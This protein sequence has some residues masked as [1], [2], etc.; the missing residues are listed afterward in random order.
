MSNGMFIV[1]ENMPEE[2]SAIAQAVKNAFGI[3]ST[4]E[5][6]DLEGVFTPI[7]EF[8]GY[9]NSST[10]LA[11]AI[12]KFK[13]DTGK[14]MEKAVFVLTPRDLY[15]GEVSKEDDWIFGYNI[16]E[17]SVASG[18]R[19]KREDSQPSDILQVKKDLYLK[20]LT[21]LGVHEIGHD[22]IDR[23]YMQ[24][25]TWVNTLTGHELLLG[26]HCTDNTCVMYE[27]VDIKTPKPTEGHMRLGTEKRFD[28][29]LDDVIQRLRPDYL[30]NNC[31]SSVKVDANYR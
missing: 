6:I 13:T 9:Q 15:A 4:I 23:S 26:P 5:G 29:G 12:R 14:G 20:R 2:A 27:V 22:V 17:I 7:P 25:A 16:G 19:M 11:L 8:N 21:V 3:E 10:G 1:H 24:L 31:R 18:A 28:A 30:C